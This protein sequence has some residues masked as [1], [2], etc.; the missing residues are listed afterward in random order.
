MDSKIEVLTELL[1]NVSKLIDPESTNSK[2]KW[3]MDSKIKN[4]LFKK[5]PK[6]TM[7]IKNLNDETFQPYFFVCNRQGMT[8]PDMI[9]FNLRL[10]DKLEK[11]NHIDKDHLCKIRRRLKYMQARYDKPIPIPFSTSGHKTKNTLRLNKIL[12]RI[13][14]IRNP[15]G[16]II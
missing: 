14:K 4:E 13:R 15:N 12:N 9:K 11:L 5:F 16:E 7:S 10:C 8:D 3:L 6:C 1:R 2:V